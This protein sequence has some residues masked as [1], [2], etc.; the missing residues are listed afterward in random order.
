MPAKLRVALPQIIQISGAAVVVL[1][2]IL[3]LLSTDNP[4]MVVSFVVG[5]TGVGS[6]LAGVGAMLLNS[7][8]QMDLRQRDSGN[9]RAMAK[10]NLELVSMI[11]ASMASGPE[12]G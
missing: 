11:E 12:N 2:L 7:D 3:A 5:G 9:L 1:S 4:L 8:L 10:A 6:A